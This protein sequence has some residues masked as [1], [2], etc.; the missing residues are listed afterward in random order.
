MLNK[1][2]INQQIIDDVCQMIF[3]GTLKRGDFLPSIRAMSDRYKVSRGTVMLVYKSLECLGYIQGHE[4]SGYLVTGTPELTEFSVSKV[5]GDTFGKEILH[6]DEN[7]YPATRIYQ[8]LE[9]HHRMQLPKHFIRRWCLNNSSARQPAGWNQSDVSDKQLRKSLCRFIRMSRGISLQ[10]DNLLLFSGIQEALLLIGKTLASTRKNVTVLV[11]DPC[12]LNVRE[13]FRCLNF[14]V[15]PVAVDEQG[16]RVEE[17]PLQG[18]DLI[19]TSPALQFPTGSCLS[20]TRRRKLYQ[21]ALRH[22]ALIIENDSSAML[23]FGQSV[24][25]PL[26]PHYPD[27]QI[28]YLTH[29][30]ELTGNGMNICCLAAPNAFMQLMQCYLPLLISETNPLTRALLS[31]FFDSSHFMK[32]LTES[33][34]TRRHK[35][36]LALEGIQQLWPETRSC[37]LNNAGFLTFRAEAKLLPEELLNHTIFPLDIFRHTPREQGQQQ[38]TMIYPFGLLSIHEIE[39]INH[40]LLISAPL[41]S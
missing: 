36:I 20:I 19:F 35:A 8:W 1:Q 26:S 2:T 33:L 37:G 18:A 28:I 7:R 22:N 3:V 24:I 41:Y 32:Y 10:P 14:K 12:P 27:P 5:A 38:Q 11:E 6:S 25:P 4:R 39:K 9:H 23:G 31:A 13:L 40:Q 17:F 30:A 21:W 16:I 15:I 29:L 34:Q